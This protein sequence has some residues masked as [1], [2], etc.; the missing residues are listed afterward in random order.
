MNLAIL[1]EEAAWERFLRSVLFCG[2]CVFCGEKPLT[3]KA[4]KETQRTPREE[5]PG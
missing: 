1:S 4:A 2:I 3:A 5:D